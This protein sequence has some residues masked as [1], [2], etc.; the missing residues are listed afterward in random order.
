MFSPN[1]TNHLLGIGCSP[2]QPLQELRVLVVSDIQNLKAASK[3]SALASGLILQDAK[4]KTGV[5]RACPAK[6]TAA[7]G[8]G[9]TDGIPWLVLGCESHAQ[10]FWNSWHDKIRG[11]EQ[12]S[13]RERSWINPL[14]QAMA[15]EGWSD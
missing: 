10:P 15:T 14:S 4:T 2:Q 5:I 3:R 6:D 13:A 8:S 11:R 9:L 7:L 12:G 1:E